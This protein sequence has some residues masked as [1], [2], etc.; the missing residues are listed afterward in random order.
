MSQ[1]TTRGRRAAIGLA[2]VLGTLVASC[3]S[4]PSGPATDSH[5]GILARLVDEAREA[6][7]APRESTTSFMW[8]LTDRNRRGCPWVTDGPTKAIHTLVR[9][10]NGS[11]DRSQFLPAIAIRGKGLKTF[12]HPHDHTA[13]EVNSA[14]V[15]FSCYG[16]GPEN[17]RVVAIDEDGDV[18]A[19]SV[20]ETFRARPEP[21]HHTF[22]L[23]SDEKLDAKRS[24][25]RLEIK[26]RKE[27]GAL[28]TMKAMWTPPGASL[29]QV[30]KGEPIRRGTDWRHAAGLIEGHPWKVDI[31]HV[32]PD[33][34]TVTVT[35]DVLVPRSASPSSRL[36]RIAVRAKGV[37]GPI[38][39]TLQVPRTAKDGWTTMKVALEGLAPG[40]S[41]VE[42]E[43]ID[44]S[45]DQ[46]ASLAIG[47]AAIVQRSDAAKIV[48]L[49]TSDTHRADHL[50]AADS[51]A[52]VD[53]PA[54]DRLG[55]RG[56]FFTN[57]QS[58][59][60]VTNPSHISVMTGIHPRDTRIVDNQTAVNI[61]V[62]TLA[63]IYTRHG[64]R[65]FASISTQHLDPSQ[66]GLGQGFDR[67][68]AP[69]VFK[70]PGNIAVDRV[71]EW[72]EE[73]DGQ[74]VF[75]WIHMFDAHAPY[76]PPAKYQ[77]KQLQGM[78]KSSDEG[79][80]VEPEFVPA[81]IRRED[82][83]NAEYVNALYRSEV[84]WLD[85]SLSRLL[86]QPRM[87]D[88]LVAFTA[89]HGETFRAHNIFWDHAGLYLP[90]LAVPLIIAGPEVDEMRTEVS[91]QQ[92]DVGRTLLDLSGIDDEF[93]GRNLIELAL[94]D[95]ADEPRFALS[96]HGLQ[97][98]ITSGKW[99]LVMD[100]RDYDTSPVK[101]DWQKGRVKLFDRSQGV[102]TEDEMSAEFPDVTE[103]LRE[104]LVEWLLDANP[105]G[106]G[107]E[108]QLNED[109]SANLEEL[110][111]AAVDPGA[112]AAW[113]VEDE[114]TEDS[115]DENSS[116]EDD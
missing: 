68:E 48:I 66:S 5:S 46:T 83:Q 43:L 41:E 35:F 4:G 10:M 17:V 115:A 59:T 44:A 88:A 26:G 12:T 75:A 39:R 73:A 64:Y 98:A 74:S 31:D 91:V 72:L 28:L 81:W 93:A 114:P 14:E 47:D 96:A 13:G 79:L 104:R 89:D 84:D 107:T 19:A 109:Q 9:P 101:H 23:I 7:E 60:N 22:Q 21:H 15:V 108:V 105:V 85:D 63:D 24:G 95:A 36:A 33:A 70:R 54:L 51:A 32:D 20:W 8:R 58:T 92:M 2:F 50:S 38:E 61:G 90:M 69:L 76:G 94:E 55:R 57:C 16:T 99:Y 49:I 86:D 67:F 97:A 42:L 82:I 113:W 18:V 77:R 53:T 25:I 112:S 62:D 27:H 80:G 29:P 52:M 110:G 6:P 56:V 71:A 103:A 78:S 65:T 37:E 30:G 3:D 102:D 45:D 1:S 106:L 34:D 100:L 40:P 116:S 87:Q 111:Y 11:K